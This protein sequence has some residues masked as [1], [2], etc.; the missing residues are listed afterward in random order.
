MSWLKKAGQLKEQSCPFVMVTVAKVR[1]HAPR[2]AGSK[3]LVTLQDVFGSVGGGNVEQLAI[4]KARQMLKSEITQPDLVNV[5]LTPQG[6]NYGVQCCGGEVTLLLE[7]I[8]MTR[9]SV[10]IFGAGHVGWALVHVLSIFPIDIHLIDSRANQLEPPYNS[11][12]SASLFKKH[13]SVPET[14]LADLPEGSHVLVMTHDHAEDIAILDWALKRND[15]AFLGLIGSSAKWTHFQKE[16]KKQNHTQTDLA[17]ITT[18]IGLAAVQGKS[19][20]AI[21]VATA[22]QLISLMSFGEADF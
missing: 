12:L 6:G 5:T 17:R 3:M 19:P 9:P 10:A 8:L 16:L 1:G 18:P 22:A 21:A 7:T 15:W 11:A 14:T 2:G 13:V 4:S 20:Q